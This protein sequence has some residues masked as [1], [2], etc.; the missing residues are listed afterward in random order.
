[1]NDKIWFKTPGNAGGGKSLIL[2]I[3]FLK[4]KK[5]KMYYFKMVIASMVLLMLSLM[6]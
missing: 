4:H 6:P 2:A 3:H 5:K 1:M